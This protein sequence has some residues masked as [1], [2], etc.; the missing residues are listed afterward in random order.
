MMPLELKKELKTN[1]L[2]AYLYCK[3]GSSLFGFNLSEKDLFTEF[4][5]KKLIEHILEKRQINKSIIESIYENLEIIDLLCNSNN[6][7]YPLFYLLFYL[8]LY[9]VKIISYEYIKRRNSDN[10]T[11]L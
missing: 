10:K 5:G 9:I 3:N 11:F 6:Y 8:S 1:A 4:D 7:F 2:A